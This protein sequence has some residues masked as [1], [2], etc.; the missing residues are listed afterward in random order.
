MD[1][2]N[3]SINVSD[4]YKKANKEDICI[5]MYTSGSTGVPKGVILKHESLIKVC[6]NCINLMNDYININD[7][8]EY[9]IVSYLP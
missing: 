6:L 3:N 5:I 9:K 7:N 8:I 1:D 2:S 4:T